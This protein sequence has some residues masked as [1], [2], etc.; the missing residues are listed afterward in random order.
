MMWNSID[1]DPFKK[2]AAYVVG[3]RY[4]LDDYTPTSTKPKTMAKHGG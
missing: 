3:T 2:G 1:I 4:K